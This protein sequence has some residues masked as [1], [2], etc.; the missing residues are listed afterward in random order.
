MATF[1]RFDLSP[2]CV[3]TIKPGTIIL[4]DREM[5]REVVSFLL[6]WPIHTPSLIRGQGGKPWLGHGACEFRQ[7]FNAGNS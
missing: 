2:A 1:F 7:S 5:E 6:Y 4:V 3:G